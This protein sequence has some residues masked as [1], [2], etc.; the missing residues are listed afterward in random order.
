MLELLK[1]MS[2]KRHLFI[3]QLG[4]GHF[5]SVGGRHQ[6]GATWWNQAGFFGAA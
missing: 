3:E 5:K 4:L 2:P 6:L 1:P